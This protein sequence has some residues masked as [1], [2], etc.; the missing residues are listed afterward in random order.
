MEVEDVAGQAG[1]SDQKQPSA[2]ILEIRVRFAKLDQVDELIQTINRMRAS[3][4][5]VVS[6]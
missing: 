3:V 4:R 5:D 2:V 1:E 6:A